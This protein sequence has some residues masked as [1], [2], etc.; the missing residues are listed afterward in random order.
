MI[1][2]A[3]ISALENHEKRINVL[4]KKNGGTEHSKEN[5]TVPEKV[6]TTRTENGNK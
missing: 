1:I 5:K 4:G 3:D 6:A 2:K